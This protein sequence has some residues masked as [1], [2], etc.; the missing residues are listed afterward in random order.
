MKSENQTVVRL[1]QPIKMEKPF[2]C[3]R[4]FPA[5]LSCCVGER[6]DCAIF[7]LVST[8]R[9]FK[10]CPLFISR[11]VTSLCHWFSGR[12]RPPSR[13]RS[14]SEC[15][16]LTPSYEGKNSGGIKSPKQTKTAKITKKRNGHTRG[17]FVLIILLKKRGYFIVFSVVNQRYFFPHTTSYKAFKFSTVPV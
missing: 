6:N 3:S 13:K 14:K 5:A 17:E 4:R 9:I 1:K 15:A 12:K 7:M 11:R 16:A 2:E 10:S 8:R